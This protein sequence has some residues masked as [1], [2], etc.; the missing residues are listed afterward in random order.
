MSDCMFMNSTRHATCVAQGQ[1]GT[2]TSTF[3]GLMEKPVRIV[4]YNPSWVSKFEMIRNF[5]T[6]VLTD[7]VVAIEH[8]GSTSVQGL[9]AKPIIDMD[10]IVDSQAEVLIA[11]QRLESIGYIHQGDLGISGREAFAPPAGLPAH[12][13]YV[14]EI[15]NAELKRHIL[16]RDYLRT[17]PD[18][19]KKYGELKQDLAKRFRNDRV[20]YTNSKTEFINER[21]K[22]SRWQE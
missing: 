20:S 8:V 9:S 12:H 1:K 21:L 14:C 15:G 22:L 18:E 17:H 10:V 2:R 16:F 11:I 3:G 4:K 6:P 5:V 19:G 7:I 13:L